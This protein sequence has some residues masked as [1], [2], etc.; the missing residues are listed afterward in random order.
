M[1]LVQRDE[2]KERQLM[3]KAGITAEDDIEG[4]NDGDGDGGLFG[5][6]DD[7][8]DMQIG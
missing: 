3:K 6:D 4:G 7:E 8:M 2:L 5:D 1:K